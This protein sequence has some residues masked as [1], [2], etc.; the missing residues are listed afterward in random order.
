MHIIHLEAPPL[1]AVDVLE[2]R[3]VVTLQH[4]VTLQQEH[5]DGQWT[6]YEFDDL[7]AIYHK[8]GIKYGYVVLDKEAERWVWLEDVMPVVWPGSASEAYVQQKIAIE[9]AQIPRYHYHTFV[10]DYT[11]ITPV[12]SLTRRYLLY[13]ASAAPTDTEL[14][15]EEELRRSI[16]H[17]AVFDP[18]AQDRDENGRLRVVGQAM[19]RMIRD[20]MSELK[21]LKCTQVNVPFL[22]DGIYPTRVGEKN[23]VFVLNPSIARRKLAL[24]H[25]DEAAAHIVAE[26]D[27]LWID[28]E[29]QRA[30][31]FRRYLGDMYGR[32]VEEDKQRLYDAGYRGGPP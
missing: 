26:G 18:R 13:V 31:L 10:P 15:S 25:M 29:E 11:P 24:A 23:P 8:N 5:A 7:L 2:G 6:F 19:G 20:T 12:D 9:Q 17:F 22:R 3:P 28:D 4:P 1:D 32:S 21:F 27:S 16:Q 14:T 30:S